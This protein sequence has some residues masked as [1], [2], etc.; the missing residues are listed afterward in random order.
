[1]STGSTRR[2][3]RNGGCL[4]SYCARCARHSASRRCPVGPTARGRDAARM[5]ARAPTLTIALHPHIQGGL[6]LRRNDVLDAV[7]YVHWMAYDFYLKPNEQP[8]KEPPLGHTDYRY[9]SGMLSDEVLEGFLDPAASRGSR[10]SKL[11]IYRDPRRKLTLGIPLFAKHIAENFRHPM[12]YKD[13][14]TEQVARVAPPQST[15]SSAELERQMA[16]FIR[17]VNELD[18]YTFS[19]YNEIQ[20]KVELARTGGPPGGIGGIMIWELGQDLLP[21]SEH[22][23]AA[24]N[25]ISEVVQ[26]RWGGPARPWT[27]EVRDGAGGVTREADAASTPTE[28][29]TAPPREAD[30][31]E[32]SD[33]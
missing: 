6:L 32:L 28:K 25:A 27:G 18:R 21:P 5:R 29:A 3:W 17:P 23:L 13:V 30:Y 16:A 12:P 31:E 26:E 1:M 22:P 24:M 7:D 33:L 10:R 20:K 14:M 4:A 8:D 11:D 2:R 19:G 9:A 15:A